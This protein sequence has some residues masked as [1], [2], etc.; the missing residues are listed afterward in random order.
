ME[1]WL[2]ASF[3]ASLL[4]SFQTGYIQALGEANY[5]LRNA[6]YNSTHHGEADTG[7][8]FMAAY[9]LD[10]SFLHNTWFG[11]FSS[12]PLLS[13]SSPLLSGPRV[14]PAEDLVEVF[15]L[16]KYEIPAYVIQLCN[17]ELYAEVMAIKV[18]SIRLPFHFPFE[19]LF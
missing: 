18:D 6:G 8:E 2:T 10:L 5:Y 1:W 3:P 4:L 15:K 7:G 17:A 13:F 16:L 14:L 11:D 12:D 9:E 19:C